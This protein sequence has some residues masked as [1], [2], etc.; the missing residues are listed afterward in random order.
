MKRIVTLFCFMTIL[1]LTGFKWKKASIADLESGDRVILVSSSVEDW[2]AIS[3]R[4]ETVAFVSQQDGVNSLKSINLL[5]VEL[6]KRGKELYFS[7]N[8]KGLD[9]QSEVFK[10]LYTNVDTS[11]YH[12]EYSPKGSKILCLSK[13]ASFEGKPFF[14]NKKHNKA[15]F[16]NYENVYTAT[17]KSDEE[18]IFC[19]SSDSSSI[20]TYNLTTNDTVLF[21]RFDKKI[22]HI[23]KQK[24]SLLIGFTNRLES[25]S[26]YLKYNGGYPIRYSYDKAYLMDEL[27]LITTS[28]KD[29]SILIDFNN[30]IVTP[31]V[32]GSKDINPV[33]SYDLRYVVVYS[34]SLKGIV[35]RVM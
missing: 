31:L 25:Y 9:P 32:K 13:S 5:A 21:K 1:I 34:K 26:L 22:K 10:T 12:P 3:P 33:L 27:N 7:K 4:N 8:L 28:S 35:L 14:F 20:Y 6:K 18:I 19:Q 17:W 2:P 16:L 29:E 30:N 15:I 24:S 11:F 23:N